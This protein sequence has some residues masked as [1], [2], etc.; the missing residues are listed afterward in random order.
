MTKRDMAIRL[1]GLAVVAAVAAMLIGA[2]A[3]RSHPDLTLWVSSP[4]LPADGHSAAQIVVEE[5]RGGFFVSDPIELEI[6]E[7]QRRARI[8]SVRPEHN[9]TG[10][11]LRAGVQ[12]GAVV[13]AA[14][15]G[16]RTEARTQVILRLDPADR[17]ADGTPDFLRLDTH[18][19]RE[20]FRR[21]FAFLAESQFFRPPSQLPA[22][23]NDCAALIRFAY[24]EGL[25][26][27][28]GAWARELGLLAPPA[29]LSIAKYH[30]PFTPL[31]ANLYRVRPGRF[32]AEDLRDRTFA[33]FADAETLYRLNTHLVSRVIQDAQPGDLLFYRQ[34]EQDLP[35]HAMMYLGASQL[36]PDVRAYVIYHTGPIAGSKGEIRRLPV[37]EL[38]RHPSPRWR[39]VP[40]NGNFLGVYRF[41]ILRQE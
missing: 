35:F 23:I 8:E 34:L 7:G 3:F 27:H 6:V 25:R 38:L 26:E 32:R 2:A 17:F 40:G 9:G 13:I 15:A 30:Y 28:T 5:K 14:R 37:D 18:T 36:E 33:Q 41:N 16:P 31:G 20:A 21:W 12:P 39:P 10:A 11:I 29:A 24:R 19:D 4:S 1:G 22:E